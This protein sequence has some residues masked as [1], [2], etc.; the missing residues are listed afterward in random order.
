ME[1][2]KLRS[3]AISGAG[4]IFDP[5]T[6]NSFNTNET[7]VFIIENLKKNFDNN[8][9]AKLLSDEFEVPIEEAE[10]DVMQFIHSMRAQYLL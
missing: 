7:G 1:L 8:Q 5:E 6:G 3:L 9:I 2:S 10:K 4:F